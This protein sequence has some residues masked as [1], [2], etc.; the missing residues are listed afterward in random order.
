MPRNRSRKPD[1][2]NEQ[3]LQMLLRRLDLL[4]EKIRALPCMA[5]FPGMLDGNVK[6][7]TSECVEPVR[8]S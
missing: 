4:A 7:D 2:P 3:E 1:T 8:P 5:D 6:A